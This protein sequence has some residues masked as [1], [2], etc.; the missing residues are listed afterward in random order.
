MRSLSVRVTLSHLLVSLGAL[1]LLTLLSPHFFRDYYARSEMRR[2]NAAVTGLARAASGLLKRGAT[3]DLDRLVRNSANV[4][5]GEVFI[6]KVSESRVLS[7]SGR[8]PGLTT[9]KRLELSRSLDADTVLILRLPLTG[10][11]YMMQAQR[12][13]TFLTAGIAALL[14]I[15]LALTL[16]RAITSPLVA[17]SQVAERL[18]AAD[19]TP[20]VP[21]KGPAE[22]ASLARSLN[23]MAD[24]LQAAFD[25][26]QRLDQL[27]REFVG[28]ASHELRAPLT[29]I[30][31]FLDAILDGTA[32][33]P[34]EQAQCLQTASAEARRMTRI[35][36]ELLELSRLQAGVLE[37]D[38]TPQDLRQIAYSVGDSFR[39]RLQ[40]RAVTL[41]IDAEP[42]PPLEVDGEKLAQVLV[43]LLDNA[44]RY[45]PEPGTIT[46]SL[47]LKGERVRVS[48]ADEGPGI[49]PE[50]LTAIWERFHKAD[51]ARPRT[52]PG[53]GLGLAIAREII[54]R[55]GGE[56]FARNR[57][58][59]GA[60]VG[61]EL[62]C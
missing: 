2:V 32:A 36:E 41:Q 42:L 30:R 44:L 60:E 6:V 19:F 21:V 22:V 33:T 49:P 45:S 55:H 43:N 50:H 39:R 24:G 11:E 58:Q 18:A 13:A 34:Q 35:V 5:G 9:D 54:Q 10:L 23:R 51:P 46:M 31:G 53:A 28:S 37:F 12:A 52:Q 40:E 48:V 59:G 15:V 26:M 17:M 25:E 38:F 14:A 16:S 7:N 3:P 4:L 61:F 29:N 20:R 1:G 47:Q 27:R 62:K 57:E 8:P 56:V